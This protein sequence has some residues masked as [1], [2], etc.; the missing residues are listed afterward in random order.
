MGKVIDVRLVTAPEDIIN[1]FN[2]REKVF[3]KEQRIDREE[4]FDKWDESSRQL[5]AFHTGTPCGTARWRMTDEGAKLERFSVLPDFRREKVGTALIRG[6]VKDVREKEGSVRMF[7][8]AQVK[9]LE[10]YSKEGFKPVGEI[11]MECGIPHQVME[12][13]NEETLPS[14]EFPGR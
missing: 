1:A 12:F 6:V 5:L 13:S 3:I 4:E 14:E 11:F 2:I 10:F 9:V 8:N 7:L